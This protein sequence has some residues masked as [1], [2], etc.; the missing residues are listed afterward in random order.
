LRFLN[1]II[2]CSLIVT[3][4]GCAFP[5]YQTVVREKDTGYQKT[6]DPKLPLKTYKAINYVKVDEFGVMTV[7]PKVI[8]EYDELEAPKVEKTASEK[9]SPDPVGTILVTGL[10]LGL[11]LLVATSDT[12]KMLTGDSKNERVIGTD[13][14]MTRAK[15]TGVKVSKTTFDKPAGPIR[16]DGLI[17]GPLTLFGEKD[18]KYDLSAYIRADTGYE[19]IKPIFITCMECNDLIP[20]QTGIINTIRY[21]INI[22]EIKNKIVKNNIPIRPHGKPG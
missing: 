4:G 2:T 20:G 21:D 9:K 12:F 19:V 13:I 15:K 22:Q 1:Q 18:N 7:N 14:D 6:Y 3:L 17:D 5:K 16:I 10:T 11:N 8:T